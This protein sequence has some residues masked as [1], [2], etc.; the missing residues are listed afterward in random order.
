M[1]VP[2]SRVYWSPFLKPLSYN[3]VIGSLM[4]NAR[5]MFHTVSPSIIVIDFD[6]LV[7]RVAICS[8]VFA[9]HSAADAC[10]VLVPTANAPMNV[11]P[12]T[13]HLVL[14]F[15]IFARYFCSACVALLNVTFF[16]L[17]P[18]IFINLYYTTSVST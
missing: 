14:T 12:T 11:I 17:I 15:F 10:V 3:N 1:T 9:T 4:F 18:P 2:T 8:G 7:I 6:S 16:I 13:T 5:P